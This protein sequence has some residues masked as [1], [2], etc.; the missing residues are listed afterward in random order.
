MLT[1]ISHV[2]LFVTDQDAA[3]S[4]YQE[5]LGMEQRS[6]QQL[7]PTYRWVTVGVPG[8]NVELVLHLPDERA[9]KLLVGKQSPGVLAS[10]DCRT[11]TE[12]FRSRGVTI[13]DEP[14]EMPYGVQS[15]FQD[16]YG[17]VWVMVQPFQSPD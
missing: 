14:R 9:Q 12:T 6:N 5:K 1:G 16:L 15:V 4:W 7:G 8:Q 2:T 13:T 10:N 17:N 11:D 3:L